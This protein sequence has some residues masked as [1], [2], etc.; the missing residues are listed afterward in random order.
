MQQDLGVTVDPLVKLDIGVGRLI[1]WKVMR[2][3]KGRLRFSRD[4]QVSKVPIVGLISKLGTQLW[5]NY[6]A[7]PHL[8]IALSGSKTEAFLKQLP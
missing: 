6:R 5:E 1:E 7:A 4:D 8:D 3:Y 2:D